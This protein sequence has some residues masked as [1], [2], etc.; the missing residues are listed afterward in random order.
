MKY[1]LGVSVMVFLAGCGKEAEHH[2][3]TVSQWRQ[4]VQDPNPKVRSEA[5]DSLGAIGSQAK[6]A[7]PDLIVALQAKDD[8][9]RAKAATAFSSI[10]RQANEAFPALTADLTYKKADL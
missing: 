1:L 6:S 2:G 7:V 3:K 8:G 5:A 10:S 9:F 4:A